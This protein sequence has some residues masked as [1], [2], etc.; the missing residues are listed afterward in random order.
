MGKTRKSWHG[1][2]WYGSDREMSAEEHVYHAERCAGKLA[3]QTR[4]KAVRAKRSKARRFGKRYSV[5]RCGY[6]GMWHLTT[7][8]WRKER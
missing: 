8:P 4:A 2:D 3:Y 7:H 5:Y 6:C 1:P